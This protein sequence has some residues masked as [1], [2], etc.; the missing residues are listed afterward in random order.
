MVH[1]K[2]MDDSMKWNGKGNLKSHTKSSSAFYYDKWKF[3]RFGL[4]KGNLQIS[5]LCKQKDGSL[6]FST[7]LY[8]ESES[9]VIGKIAVGFSTPIYITVQPQC[10]SPYLLR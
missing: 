2:E 10:R 8:G 7:I 5:K 1:R 3:Q 4:L 6:K 9:A